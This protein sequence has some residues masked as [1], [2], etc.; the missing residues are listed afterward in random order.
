[1]EECVQLATKIFIST[2]QNCQLD[3]AFSHNCLCWYCTVH[4]S[5]VH[6]VSLLSYNIIDHLSCLA[7]CLLFCTKISL[8][9]TLHV[10][11]PGL[12]LLG[13]LYNTTPT[14]MWYKSYAWYQY[15]TSRSCMGSP[16]PCM[17]PLDTN[18]DSGNQV[19]TLRLNYTTWFLACYQSVWYKWL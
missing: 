15:T 9:S 4:V 1:M 6:Y 10:Q 16:P 14:V 3:N 13:S 7:L 19:D 17:Y 8:S 2:A 12:S 5:T 18:I 11:L